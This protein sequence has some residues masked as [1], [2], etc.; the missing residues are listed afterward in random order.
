MEQALRQKWARGFGRLSVCF[1]VNLCPCPEIADAL[2]GPEIFA[3]QDKPNIPAAIGGLPLQKIKLLKS[4]TITALLKA[5]TTIKGFPCAP[6]YIHFAP[7]GN[8]RAF[9]LAEATAVQG[10]DIPKGTWLQLDEALMLKYCSFPT[11]TMIQGHLCRGTGG[12]KGV[13]TSFYPSGRLKGFYAPTSIDIQGIPCKASLF[14][15]IYL[16][17]NG[18]LKECTLSR[19]RTV[20]GKSLPKGARAIFSESGELLQ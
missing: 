10:N 1:C 6:G 15:P 18:R 3:D 5:P 12:P 7:S 19:A 2:L 11:D 20:G 17:E 9:T 13:S 14:S 8:L 16:F 4:G